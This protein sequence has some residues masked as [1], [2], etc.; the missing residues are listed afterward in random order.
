MHM[1][2][3]GPSLTLVSQMGFTLVAV[4]DEETVVIG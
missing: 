1:A 3:A 2:A 4:K